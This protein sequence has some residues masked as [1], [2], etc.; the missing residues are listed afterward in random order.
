MNNIKIGGFRYK[1]IE[2]NMQMCNK[3]YLKDNCVSNC[4]KT[5]YYEIMSES[6]VYE[7]ILNEYL[8]THKSNLGKRNEKNFKKC[9]DD[10]YH[11][12]KYKRNYTCKY[13]FQ[14]G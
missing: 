13:L 7:E 4:S 9:C 8:K 1:W 3:C 11:I 10:Y 2:T 12:G 6:E 5:G 14:Q